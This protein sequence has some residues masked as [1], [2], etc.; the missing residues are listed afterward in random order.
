MITPDH[1]LLRIPKVRNKKSLIVSLMESNLK[2]HQ[3]EC[4]WPSAQAELASLGAY[5]TSEDKVRCVVRTAKIIMNLLSM[6]HEHSV[7]AADDFTPV[8]IYV[9]IMV[10]AMSLLFNYVLS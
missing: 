8:L 9:I 2:V 10:S 7:P 3:Y 1:K 6:A 4:P 5:K